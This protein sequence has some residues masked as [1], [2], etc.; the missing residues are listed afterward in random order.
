ME[1]EE[2]FRQLSVSEFSNIALGE[3]GSGAIREQ[4]K[5]AIVVHLNDAL[6]CLYT[7]FKIREKLLTIGEIEGKSLYT[8]SYAHALSNPTPTAPVYIEDSVE[9][10][11]QDDFI[12]ALQATDSEGEEYTFNVKGSVRSLYTPE[13]NVIQIPYAKAGR[14][15]AIIY[16]AKPKEIVETGENANTTIDLP[17]ILVPALRYYI[18]HLVYMNMNNQQNVALGQMYLGR[19]EQE[20]ARIREHDLLTE[21]SSSLTSFELNGWI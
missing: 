4:D 19:Y 8:I 14:K 15:M 2:L 20:C 5:K 12:R 21:G 17:R 16:Q 9:E 18:A 3:K 10:P 1:L 11:F 6:L 13:P 7:R